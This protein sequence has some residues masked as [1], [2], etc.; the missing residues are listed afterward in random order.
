M[1]D[2][3]RIFPGRHARIVSSAR[4]RCSLRRCT[5]C[6]RSS[7]PRRLRRLLVDAPRGTRDRC[8]VRSAGCDRRIRP[9]RRRTRTRPAP[10]QRPGRRAGVGQSRAGVGRAWCPASRASTVTTAVEVSSASSP[11]SSTTRPWPRAAVAA[12]SSAADSVPVRRARSLTATGRGGRTVVEWA[13]SRRGRARRSREGALRGTREQRRD[14][15]HGQQQR[16]RAS[17]Q[18][19]VGRRVIWRPAW[20][21]QRSARGWQ[22]R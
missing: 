6:S 12:S 13:P 8:R 22:R 11:P 1:T 21:A 15:D 14:Q 7:S 5:R 3:C 16:S 19:G 4:R 2:E 10:A 20:R 9:A 17:R 18:A